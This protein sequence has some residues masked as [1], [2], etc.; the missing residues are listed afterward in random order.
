[1]TNI[2]SKEIHLKNRPEG[3]PS[4][5]D[6]ELAEVSLPEINDGEILVQNIFISVDP[7]MRGRMYDRKSDLP[8]FPLGQ[9]LEG[10]SVVR[11]VESKNDGFKVDDY[12]LR[13]Y[14]H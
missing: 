10:G 13:R 2:T 1:M 11:V 4:K 12:V 3:L 14:S 6:F 5:S 7:Y 8:P 9:P